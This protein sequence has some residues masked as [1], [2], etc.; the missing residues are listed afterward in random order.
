MNLTESLRMAWETLRGN[1]LRS[2]L[3][4]LGMV[5]GVFSVIAAVTAVEVIDVY[6]KEAFRGMGANAF[7]I[8]KYGG[9]FQTGPM[10]PSLRNRPNLTYADML[11]LRERARLAV[12]VSPDG[13]FAFTAIKSAD[14]ETDPNIAV[15][16]VG[17]DWAVNNGYDVEDGRFLTE[18]D[19]RYGRPVVV[20][21][22]I[23]A[24][25][26][27]PTTRAVGKE[28][29]IDGRR[30]RVVGVTAEKGAFLG[31]SNDDLVWAPITRLFAVYGD[32]DR[33]IAY[34][35]R[36]PSPELITPTIDEVTGLLRSIRRVRPEEENNFEVVTNDA[37]TG[38][39]ESFTAVLTMGGAGIGLIAL[40]AAGVGIMNI[41]LVSVT[42]RT[43]EIGIRKALGATRRAVLTQ[44]LVEAVF[45]CQI[46]GLA[47][48]LLGVL[49]GNVMALTF[50]I[51]PAFPW[52]WA[53]GGVLGVTAI[54]LVFGVYPAYKAAR[55]DPIEALRYE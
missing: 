27:F 8:V 24:E 20:L 30:Y 52:G 38:P 22:S 34:D 17:A 15:R 19:V 42:E 1:K 11:E 7:Y 18:D 35:V 49:G 54:A 36:A 25:R 47:G 23:V 16:G 50:G 55:L 5:I 10:D 46:G 21:G 33:N 37:L 2:L 6:F 29:R 14:E 3:T 40:L 26:L 4:L 44:F 12:S 45:L 31:E 41:M 51:S 53:I 43:R 28:V 13:T 39:L 9:G 32:L 48:I